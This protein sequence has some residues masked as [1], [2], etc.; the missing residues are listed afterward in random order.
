MLKCKHCE[1]T[2]EGDC[3]SKMPDG[4][5]DT[6]GCCQYYKSCS[7]Q[8][9]DNCLDVIENNATP[10]YRDA[11]D[12]GECEAPLFDENTGLCGA[13]GE[14]SEYCGFDEVKLRRSQ[15]CQQ[16]GFVPEEFVDIVLGTPKGL[17]NNRQSSF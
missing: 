6:T 15:E 16:V 8:V 13:D 5:A 9:V 12:E 2:S 1:G 11:K 3:G 14:W 4:S 7:R 10:V 17:V